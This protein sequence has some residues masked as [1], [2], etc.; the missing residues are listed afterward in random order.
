MHPCPTVVAVLAKG[1]LRCGGFSCFVRHIR[2]FPLTG[3][4]TFVASRPPRDTGG[5]SLLQSSI[6]KRLNGKP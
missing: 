1:E 4:R 6:L 2:S 5:R 3:F